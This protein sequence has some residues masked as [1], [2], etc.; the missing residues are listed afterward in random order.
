LSLKEYVRKHIV[1][2]IAIEKYRENGLGITFEDIE[3]EFSVNKA[4]AQ[5]TLKHF[6][7]RKV[8]FTANDLILGGITV[9]KNT[10]PQQY[11]PTCI[12]SKIVEGLSKRESVLV[13]PTGVNH[14][15]NPLSSLVPLVLNTNDQIILETLE[16]HILPLLPTTPSYIHN[17]HLKLGIIPQCYVE[18]G[19]PTIPGNKGKKTT[20]VPGTSKV[21][22]TFYPNGTVNVE[23]MCSNNPFRLQTEEDRSRL[24][25]F[26]GQIEQVLISVLS[27]SHGRIVPNVLEWEVTECDINK[28]VKVS[29][30]FHYAGLRIQVKHM[31]RLFSL[32][33]KKMGKDTVYR[34]E[35]RKHPHIPALDFINDIFNPMEKV[36]KQIAVLNTK[37]SAIYDVVSKPTTGSE[38]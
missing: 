34:V 16:G 35:E 9:L 37:I 18:L 13:N 12:K 28:D 11:F 36:E 27:A 14:S 38:S 1:E 30:W 6:H 32:Y 4:K 5:R 10:S 19:L 25:V 8:L 26:L 23:V 15:S 20:E 22:Y 3:R 21:D 2:K 31:D 7:E 29:D 17:I 24:L 33:I